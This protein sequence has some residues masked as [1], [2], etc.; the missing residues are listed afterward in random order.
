[1]YPSSGSEFSTVA[2]SLAAIREATGPHEEARL[3]EEPLP[4]VLGAHDAVTG[5]GERHAAAAVTKA[6]ATQTLISRPQ[7]RLLP[8]AFRLQ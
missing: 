1:M 2:R 5:S 6:S 4:S 7:P 3:T 8:P